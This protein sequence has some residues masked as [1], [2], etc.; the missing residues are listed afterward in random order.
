MHLFSIYNKYFIFSFFI[1]ETKINNFFLQR[2]SAIP[3]YK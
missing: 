3:F 1:Y 2:L